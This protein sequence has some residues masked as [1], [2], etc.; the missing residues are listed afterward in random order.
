VIGA[1][2]LACGVGRSVPDSV[3]PHVL[4]VFAEGLEAPGPRLS[5]LP[6]QG[7]MAPAVRARARDE[8]AWLTG[9]WPSEMLGASSGSTPN[10]LPQVLQLYGYET[11][12]LAGP[13]TLSGGAG[14]KFDRVERA[15]EE[16]CPDAWIPSARKKLADAAGPLFLVVDTSA[17]A[18]ADWDASLGALLDELA[19]ALDQAL[20]IVEPAPGTDG[21]LAIA[22]KGAAPR[23]VLAQTPDVLPTVLGFAR[24]VVPSDA[25]GTSLESANVGEGRPTFTLDGTALVVRG[26][27]AEI[28]LDR[29]PDGWPPQLSETPP[30]SLQ[31]TRSGGP[32]A[33][34]DPEI[35]RLWPV[36]RA[37]YG[38]MRATDARTRMGS[39][40]FETMLQEHGYW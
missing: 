28:R 38:R 16:R 25:H 18:C 39:A 33:F 29:P 31:A 40:A 27:P 20:V 7:R 13:G 15:P 35:L 2:L 14:A 22:T 19:P 12:G 26:G 30:P 4:L 10:V 17:S 32:V 11:Y 8:E 3:A 23:E 5:A 36:V 6:I 21:P 24:A 37:W 34:D 1:L 9:M